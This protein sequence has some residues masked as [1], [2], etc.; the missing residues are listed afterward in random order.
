MPLVD[1]EAEFRDIHD[2]KRCGFTLKNHR[3]FFKLFVGLVIS[4]GCVDEQANDFRKFDASV[5]PAVP[6]R[7]RGDTNTLAIRDEPELSLSASS[8]QGD[9]GGTSPVD[10]SD[11]PTEATSDVTDSHQ[12]MIRTLRGLHR[13]NRNNP[14]FEGAL[15]D[16]E[17]AYRQSLRSGSRDRVVPAL[18]E[19]GQELT[20][21]GQPEAAMERFGEMLEGLAAIRRRSPQKVTP[22]MEASVYLAMA[23]AAIRKGETE[24]CVHCLDGQGCLFPIGPAGVHQRREGSEL[25]SQYLREVLRRKPNHLA[26]M[27]LL[28]IV[29][30][31]LGQYPENV[32][33]RYRIREERLRSE[34]AFPTFRNIATDLGIDTLSHAGGVVADDLDGDGDLDLFVSSWATDGRCRVYRNDG[35]AGFADVTEAAGLVGIVGGLNVRQFDFDGDGDLDIIMLRGAW[36]D[37]FGNHPNSLLENLG[38]L[39]FRDVAYDL[40]VAG[41]DLDR[42]TQTCT[43]ADFDG[44]GW[45]DL[46]IGN[47]N[48]PNQ[49]LRFDGTR[50][51]DVAKDWGVDDDGFCKGVATTDVDN[52]GD[53]DLAISNMGG[54]NFLYRNDGNGKF[55]RW[56]MA[57]DLEPSNSFSTWFFD[58][59]NDGNQDLFFSAYGESIHQIAADVFQQPLPNLTH[60]RL[61]R[62]HGD[63][64]FTD[65]SE[66]VGLGRISHTMGSNFGDLNND[67]FLDFYLSTGSP[68]IDALQPN[69][70]YLNQLGERFVDV[71][72]AGG[73]SHLQKGHA[74]A[75]ADFDE[76]GDQ[77]VFAELGGA[78]R[79]DAFQNALFDNP[80]DSLPNSEAAYP[81]VRFGRSWVRLDLMAL[82]NNRF[83]IGSR[84][85]VRFRDSQQ[86]RTVYRDVSSGSSFGG[87]PLRLHIGLG[88]AETIEAVTVRWPDSSTQVWSELPVRESITLRQGI[89]DFSSEARVA[90]EWPRRN[91]NASD[92]E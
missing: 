33:E 78:Y 76:D 91:R 81:E 13:E 73:F 42:P 52:D 8:D 75:F 80:M 53:M 90:F 70:M 22:D 46:Y 40:G 48:R 19:Y 50:Y 7:T 69:L 16:S 60:D 64:T 84:V 49:M 17:A 57:G 66:A 87:N 1:H 54:V 36:L 47:E 35:D 65:V 11:P 15:K 26:A 83:A 89:T 79:G 21:D 29:E 12:R 62:G 51:R 4:A 45:L 20:R 43:V 10:G 44:D 38:D 68:S 24:N 23:V 37:R 56:D 59:D 18:F 67:G 72:I 28:N 88:D 32:P 3:V 9:D 14:F 25:A 58:Y 30:M 92:D 63:G 85:A 74:I 5:R 41:P 86:T 6:S 61:Y 55:V 77:D 2:H 27:W 31:T 39:R 34:I 82:G 71:S